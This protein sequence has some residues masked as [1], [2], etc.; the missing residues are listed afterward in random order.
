MSAGQDTREGFSMYCD[1][2]FNVMIAGH[3]LN[4]DDAVKV[5]FRWREFNKVATAAQIRAEW[6]MVYGLHITFPDYYDVEDYRQLY[7]SAKDVTAFYDKLE[8]IDARTT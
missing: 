3:R 5:P 1:K 7:V 8:T 2:D 4:R 6:D